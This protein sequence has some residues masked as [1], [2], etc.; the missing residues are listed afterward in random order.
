MSEKSVPVFIDNTV[1][2]NFAKVARIDLLKNMLGKSA[3][4]T[5]AVK[6]EYQRGAE[7]GQVPPNNLDDFTSVTLRKEEMEFALERFSNLG[8]GER[9][10][11][12][13]AL[14]YRGILA[15]DDRLA[16]KIAARHNLHV[17]G[18]IGFLVFAV[19]DNLLT[20]TEANSLL[21]SMISFG[22]YSPTDSVDAFLL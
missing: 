22:Y 9:T 2:T 19:V 18:T 4:T 13:L 8:E 17:T 6:R 10:C 21:E 11:L 16:R 3:K 20:L 7:L 1:L 12:I 15:T 5:L 14:R